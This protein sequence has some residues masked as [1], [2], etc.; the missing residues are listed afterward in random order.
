MQL[1]KRDNSAKAR[2]VK[3]CSDEDLYDLSAKKKVIIFP[4]RITADE[5]ADSIVGGYIKSIE[6][7]FHRNLIQ[8]LFPILCA[9][10]ITFSIF[11]CCDSIDNKYEKDIGYR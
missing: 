2:A 9:L 1:L 3:R 5:N 4:G 10:I 8:V 6:R 7:I 11:W